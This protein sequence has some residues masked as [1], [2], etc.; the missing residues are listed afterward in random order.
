MRPTGGSKVRDDMRL[1]GPMHAQRNGSSVVEQVVAGV[2]GDEFD[3]ASRLKP[4]WPSHERRQKV[5]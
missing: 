4:V 3:Q 5:H 1:L 2:P